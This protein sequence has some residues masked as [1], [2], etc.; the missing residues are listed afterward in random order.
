MVT[1]EKLIGALGGAFTTKR[2]IADALGYKDTKSVERYVDGLDRLGARY[3][4]EDVAD[5]IME[6]VER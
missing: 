6:E 1:R 5:R 4:S 3:W 2:K